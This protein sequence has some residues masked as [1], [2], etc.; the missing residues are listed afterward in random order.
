MFLVNLFKSFFN[1]NKKNPHAMMLNEA[2]PAKD[3]ASMTKAELVALGQHHGVKLDMRHTK[4]R[5]IN[6]LQE[7]GIG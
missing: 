2:P 7:N 1:C 3:L 6:T 4:A 5:M